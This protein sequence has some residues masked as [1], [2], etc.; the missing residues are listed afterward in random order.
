MRSVNEL[1][2]TIEALGPDA[3]TIE[4]SPRST[5]EPPALRAS[6]AG[7]RALEVL[8]R[9]GRV[10]TD[11]GA[12]RLVLEDTLGEGGMG[13]VRLGTQVA[14]G[15]KVAVKTLRADV[16]PD[17][18]TMKLLREAWVTGSLEHPN[19]VPVYDVGLDDAGRPVIVLKRIGGTSWADVIDD[20]KAVDRRFGAKDLLEWNLGILMQVCNA[21]HFAH[22]RGIVHRD[23]KPENVMIGEFG[24]VYL[25]DWGIAVALADD[26]TG[27][28]P[29]ASSA[30]E[31]AGTP[32][33]MAPE[34]LGGTPS[35]ISERTDVYLLGAV[36][37][38][39]VTG[40]PPHEGAH[41]MEIVRSVIS[42]PR[43]LPS[44]VPEELA[45]ICTRAL[46]PDPH[47]RFEN[48]E[49]LRLA[50][51]GFL[52]HR[53]S[54]LLSDEAHEKLDDLQAELG[55]PG[56]REEESR[57]RIYNLFG[58]CRFG[59]RQALRSWPENQAAMDGLHDAV[60]TM[61][62]HEL[63]GG[64]AKAASVLL[65]ELREVPEALRARVE[66]AR[67][68]SERKMAELER[69]RRDQDQ[70][71][72]A[73]TRVFF[74]FVL[75]VIWTVFPLVLS[76]LA[77]DRNYVELAFGNAALLVFT[78]GLAYWA[79][80]SLSKTAFNRR[81]VMSVL[82]LF[83]VQLVLSL[84][85]LLLGLPPIMV[86]MLMPLVWLVFAGLLAIHVDVRFA[87]LTPGLLLCL[88]VAILYPDLRYYLMAGANSLLVVL[89]LT[90]WARDPVTT[91]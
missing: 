45:R 44:R 66:E 43:P 38:E 62:E 9:I 87:V 37:R 71:V 76:A 22:S 56:A 72:G 82:Y 32:C 5:I 33:Y 89:L 7:R 61:I 73:R 10:T 35:R 84:A 26:G 29:L 63:E 91:S 11:G 17:A 36:L 12:G 49:Q 46:D 15:R 57:A 74:A 81:L 64:D 16:A 58:E 78:G 75:G 86:E 19:V 70:R 41:V 59:F 69:L 52:Q 30:T 2:K 88:F 18:G 50:I 28:F 60:V 27:R 68:Q 65:A 8:E 24:E 3:D 21:V 40:R 55:A 14:L 47:A 80:D 4:R 6:T 42:P 48:A 67:R 20:P 34:M 83:L 54:M 77:I 39:I 53:G 51:A 23:L 31:M 79:R 1:E 90:T 85:C 13:V 25:L